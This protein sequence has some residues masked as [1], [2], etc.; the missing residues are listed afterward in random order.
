MQAVAETNGPC[1]PAATAATVR[2]PA[3]AW[4][5]RHGP[6]G[7]N[8]KGVAAVQPAV[9]IHRGPRGDGGKRAA[10]R[11]Q[12][13]RT[14]VRT[15]Q[16]KHCLE[17]RTETIRSVLLGRAALVGPETSLCHASQY[18]LGAIGAKVGAQANQFTSARVEN[19]RARNTVSFF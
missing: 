19:L 18:V 6:S 4:G 15:P 9:G 16:R 13:S 7:D 11:G 5:P 2:P 10:T 12:L 8:G 3:R 14:Q 1:I 17:K